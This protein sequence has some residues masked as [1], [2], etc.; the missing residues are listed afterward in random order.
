MILCGRCSAARNG[1]STAQ[2]PGIGHSPPPAGSHSRPSAPRLHTCRPASGCRPEPSRRF[3]SAAL[4]SGSRTWAWAD[5]RNKTDCRMKNAN[6]EMQNDG[7]RPAT[8]HFAL[9]NLYFAF[10]A[11]RAVLHARTASPPYNK[12]GSIARQVVL[13]E[14]HPCSVHRP[15]IRAAR[16]TS[17]RKTSSEKSL[18]EKCPISGGGIIGRVP[19]RIKAGWRG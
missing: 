16:P 5:A 11:R 15:R 7:V 8:L 18:R 9:C 19:E 17:G 2:P 12:S 3:G 1:R 6:C 4:N 13:A 10:A 14:Q